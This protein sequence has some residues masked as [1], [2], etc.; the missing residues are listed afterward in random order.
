MACVKSH[1]EPRLGPPEALSFVFLCFVFFSCL[2]FHF[3]KSTSGALFRFRRGRVLHG[4]YEFCGLSGRRSWGR[5]GTNAEG[6]A[7]GK[8]PPEPAVGTAAGRCRGRCWNSRRELEGERMLAQSQSTPPRHL[9][10]TKG[11]HS[12]LR[13]EHSADAISAQHPKLI[14]IT[15]RPEPADRAGRAEES[16]SPRGALAQMHFL[17]YPERAPGTATGGRPAKY[18][19]DASQSIEVVRHTATL[20]SPYKL[21]GAQETRRHG[22]A[23]PGLDPETEKELWWRNEGSPPKTVV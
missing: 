20:R 4:G 22:M 15:R 2:P 19:G 16:T 8:P 3:K 6:R 13:V 1:G 5:Q 10:V 12:N 17:F 14:S 9:S 23:D 11:G 21:K 7:R 18:L